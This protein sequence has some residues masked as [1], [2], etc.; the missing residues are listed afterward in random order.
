MPNK[1]KTPQKKSSKGGEKYQ[2]TELAKV[3]GASVEQNN[4]YAVIVDSGFPYKKTIKSKNT[5]VSD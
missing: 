5:G 4:F 3:S 2:Y 1:S